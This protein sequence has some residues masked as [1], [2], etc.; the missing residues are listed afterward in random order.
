[1]SNGE[2]TLKSEVAGSIENQSETCDDGK[3]KDES[4]HE[5]MDIVRVSDESVEK[6]TNL[7]DVTENGVVTASEEITITEESL[8][9]DSKVTK[10]NVTGL[11]ESS[12]TE[13]NTANEDTSPE[14]LL[15]IET[16]LNKS[17][18]DDATSLPSEVEDSPLKV[19]I[20]NT[21]QKCKYRIQ[22]IF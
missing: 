10:S 12:K 19:E 14:V 13:L 3:S 15:E 1:M 18:D 20:P 11:D 7:I 4:S 22:F 8:D 9:I 5:N 16:N 21:H 17:K 2:V 6:V